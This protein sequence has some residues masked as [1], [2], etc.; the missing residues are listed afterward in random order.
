[1]LLQGQLKK[2]Q[3]FIMAELLK[4]SQ[5]IKDQSKIIRTLSAENKKLKEE[6]SSKIEE[7]IDDQYVTL[8]S[9]D[10]MIKR[11]NSAQTLPVPSVC[12]SRDYQEAFDKVG[13]ENKLSD[14]S[15]AKELVQE[16]MSDI[17]ITQDDVFKDI[18]FDLTREKLAPSVNI[19]Q[20]NNDV[21]PR[22]R[23]NTVSVPDP[24]VEYSNHK[25]IKRRKNGGQEK[26]K[27]Q[28]NH[29]RSKHMSLDIDLNKSFDS[30]TFAESGDYSREGHEYVNW[31][32]SSSDK[33][34][35]DKVESTSFIIS[36]DGE[37]SEHGFDRRT[38]GIF[39]R[40]VEN[41]LRHKTVKRKRKRSKSLS[42]TNRM[43]VIFL[44]QSEPDVIHA[45][46]NIDEAIARKHRS[47]MQ[48]V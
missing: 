5:I 14:R 43:P 20:D 8:A 35:E 9:I 27:V 19:N 4:K 18:S 26:N 45:E 10:E 21:L 1:M 16:S 48:V 42:D 41:I 3:Q 15:S 36:D 6:S 38:D 28:S 39:Y 2:E 29:R 25:M 23:L 24:T 37:M 11:K 40:D 13:T 44:A 47:R 12:V 33:E 30:V 34:N 46:I 31:Y 17:N 22:G 7:N 32:V